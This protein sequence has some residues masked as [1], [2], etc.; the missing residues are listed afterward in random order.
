[1][2]FGVPRTDE[3][4]RIFAEG[5]SASSSWPRA[6]DDEER[7]QQLAVHAGLD[8]A[9]FVGAIARARAQDEAERGELSRPPD[10]NPKVAA[11]S[12]MR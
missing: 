2:H 3:L 11:S 9:N 1:M 8:F 7:R 4:E 6:D 10:R 5:N 12:R